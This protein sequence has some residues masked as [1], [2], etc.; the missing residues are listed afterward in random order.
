VKKN[1]KITGGLLIV[2]GYFLVQ[3]FG[4][5]DSS[6]RKPLSSDYLKDKTEIS[7]FNKADLLENRNFSKEIDRLR[8]SDF[9][10]F[11]RKKTAKVSSKNNK[12][13]TIKKKNKKVAEKKKDKKKKKKKG[14]KKTTDA[15][16][17]VAEEEVTDENRLEE[18]PETAPPYVVTQQAPLGENLSYWI[19]LLMSQPTEENFKAFYQALID[20]QISLEAYQTSLQYIYENGSSSH[21]KQLSKILQLEISAF[22]FIMSYN[23]HE[24][25]IGLS[26]SEKSKVQNYLLSYGNDGTGL[27]ALVKV[28][29][30]KEEDD[31]VSLAARILLNSSERDLANQS[32]NSQNRF[33]QTRGESVPTARNATENIEIYLSLFNYLQNEDT[34]GL[35][36]E[37]KAELR[38]LFDFLANNLGTGSGIGSRNSSRI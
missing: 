17:E 2:L 8:T 31:S 27:K 34:S 5:L 6:P 29:P 30:Q 13:K 38:K 1:W 7:L 35:N 36:S 14:K 24:K 21:Y 12:K 25:G 26:K 10:D 18:T 19:N 22:A 3:F 16:E 33:N 23:I 32:P 11:K 9:S 20:E 15:A 37:A 4:G 28:L